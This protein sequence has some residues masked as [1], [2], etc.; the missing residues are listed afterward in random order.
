MVKTSLEIVVSANCKDGTFRL[1]ANEREQVIKDLENYEWLK[2]KL[3]LE[4]MKNE[5]DKAELKKILGE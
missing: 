2:S 4:C 1:L 3:S 5:Q